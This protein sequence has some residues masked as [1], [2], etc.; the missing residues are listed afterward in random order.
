MIVYI[1]KAQVADTCR[2]PTSRWMRSV[3]DP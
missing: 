2:P 3:I 1:C